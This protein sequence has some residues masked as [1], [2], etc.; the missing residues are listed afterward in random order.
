VIRDFDSETNERRINTYT[1][2]GQHEHAYWTGALARRHVPC[3][4]VWS[5]GDFAGYALLVAPHLKIVTPALAKKLTDY[6]HAG[7]TLVLGAQSGLKDINCHI[8]EATPPGLLAKLAG[9]EIEDWSTLAEGETRSA[10]LI[11]GKEISMKVFVERLRPTTATPIAHWIG[12]DGILGQAPAVTWNEV[13]KGKV[14][15][16]GGYCAGDSIGT[17]VDSFRQLIGL[18]PA[19]GASENV[20]AVV[21]T[22]TKNYV[23]LLNHTAG[24]ERV[25]GLGRGKNLI[26]GEAVVDGEILLGSFGVAVVE[27]KRAAHQRR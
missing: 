24:P 20:E 22:A 19:V 17:L 1:K 5:N 2:G 12:G 10:R 4:Y 14:F 3:D 23:V 26:T 8:V 21:R 11:Q 13:G 25:S 27:M 15:Y 7:G 6:V 18:H 16:F 9:V